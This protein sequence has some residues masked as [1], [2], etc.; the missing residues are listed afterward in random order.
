MR[1]LSPADY[2]RTPWKNGGGITTELA[3]GPE[4][5]TLSDFHWRVSIAEVAADGPF[6]LFPG[7]DRTIMLIEGGGMILNAGDHGSIAL[8]E[9]LQAQS[10]S[11]DWPVFGRLVSGR[12]RDFNLIVRRDALHGSLKAIV[13]DTGCDVACPAGAILVCHILKANTQTAGEGDTLIT[14]HNLTLTASGHQP[15]TAILAT[16]QGNDRSHRV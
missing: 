16:I 10:F 12:V 5:A 1:R 15:V 3:V 14:D 9:P 11:G 6:S 8:L 4:N 13:F 2:R 7:S